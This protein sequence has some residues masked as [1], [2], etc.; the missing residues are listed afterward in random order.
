ME[1]AVDVTSK[2]DHPGVADLAAHRQRQEARTAAPVGPRPAPAPAVVSFNRRELQDIL[3]VYGRKVAAGEWR[4]YALDFT[5]A[6]A[7]F[8]IYRRT[9]EVPLYRVEKDP[10]L[11]Q[12]QGAYSVVTATGLIMKRGHDLQRV[13]A[14]LDKPMKLV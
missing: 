6:K 14:V 12:K 2:N 11:A 10:K 7:I 4:D 9:S 5:P 13:L 1:C 8:S 3:G